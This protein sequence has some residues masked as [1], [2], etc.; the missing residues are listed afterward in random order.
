MLFM[1]ESLKLK[2]QN[3][4]GKENV[5]LEKEDLENYSHD[6]IQEKKYFPEAVVKPSTKEEIS[7]ILILEI[8]R[9]SCRE[10]V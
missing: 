4:C 1:N 8:G 5:F 10:R 2:L 3:I 7:K 9:A 6:E